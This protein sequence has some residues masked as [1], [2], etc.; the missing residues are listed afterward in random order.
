VIFT[1]FR[2]LAGAVV[3]CSLKEFLENIPLVRWGAN[4]YENFIESWK[5]AKAAEIDRRAE[6][7]ALAQAPPEEVRRQAVEI[8]LELVPPE[9]PHVEAA[10]DKLAG[11]LQQMPAVVRRTLTRRDDPTGR[12]VPASLRLD[13]AADVRPLL[14]ARPPRFKAGDRPAGVGDWEL[15]E[16]LG[17]GGFGEVWKAKNPFLA[18]ADPAA[19]KFCLDESAK[20]RL[21]RHEAHIVSQVKA[22]GKHRGIVELRHTYLTASP[23]CLEYEF[24]DG[25]DL[26]AYALRWHQAARPFAE[27]IAWA[28]RLIHNL[29]DTLGFAHRLEPP[30]VH[31]DLKPANILLQRR[32]DGAFDVRVADFGIG[33]IVGEQLLEQTK[34]S[35]SNTM[36]PPNTILGAYTPLYA[37]QEQ[38][39]REKPD[40]RDDVH[41]LG[42]IWYQLLTGNLRLGAP[43]GLWADD[44]EEAGMSRAMIRL[45]GKC[46][47]AEAR[48]R[49]ADAR[50]LADQ[51]AGLLAP[52]TTEPPQSQPAPRQVTASPPPLSS[53]KAGEIETLDLGG[54]VSMRFAWIPE[55]TFYM[56][57]GGGTPGSQQFT[58]ADGFG[59]GVFPVTQEQWQ[60]VM[61]NNPSYFSRNG[62]G[63]NAVKGIPEAEL[64]Q[65]PVEQVSWDDAQQFINKLNERERDR[66]WLYRLPTEVEWEYACRG[67]AT[68]SKDCSFHFYL[69]QQSNDFSSTEANFDGNHP[70]GK[71]P[72]G[73]YLQRTTKV[74]SYKPNR[75]GLYDMHGNVYDWCS[76][77]AEDG[78]SRVVRGGGWSFRGSS[79]QAAYRN[80]RVPS[81]RYHDLGL[82]LARVPS[83]A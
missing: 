58:I 1:A 80:R 13:S 67:G 9:T 33:Q 14:P 47:A 27:T 15:V 54:N 72:K 44:L 30:I 75:L 8:A 2:C 25:G 55:G 12:T 57:G 52:S 81:G 37:S 24:I 45:L 23:P 16:L 49:P 64:R 65:F 19:L 82:R 56:G 35:G 42:V 51:L 6:L 21:L 3:K 4:V 5:K 40:P 79:C 78:S 11:Y 48:H 39:N 32:R 68:S 50:A 59:L 71:A 17:V 26:A 63:E 77:M 69:D 76:D 41:A 31:R 22:E 53:R 38:Q 18:K 61:G 83:G 73:N 43:T 46:V 20:D 34:P 29:A 70:E 10:R 74:G 60:A 62:G 66:G 28:A 7:Q 36:A